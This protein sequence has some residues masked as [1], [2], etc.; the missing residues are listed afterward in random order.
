MQI[1]PSGIKRSPDPNGTESTEPDFRQGGSPEFLKAMI[2][3]MTDLIF[4]KDRQHRWVLLNDAFCN[5]MGCSQTELS[6]K[7]DRDFLPDY[8]ADE[9]VFITG[10]PNEDEEFLIET[11]GKNHIFSIRK[12]LFEDEVGNQFLLGVMRDVTCSK[13]VEAE[14]RQ[15]N[16]RLLASVRECTQALL[17]SEASLLRLTDNVPGIIYQFRLDAD[18]TM[19]FPFVSSGCRDIIKLEPK[20]VQQDSALMFAT[21]HPDDAEALQSA[22][23]YSAQTLQIW[24]SEH[25]A[26][27]TD[28]QLKWIKAISRPT[29]QPDGSILWDGCLIDISDQ[30]AALRERER[31]EAELQKQTNILQLILDSMSDGVIVADE[32]GKVLVFNP[33]A[34]RIFIKAEPDSLTSE[35]SQQYG[36]FL[37]DMETPFPKAQTP[38]LQAIQGK[39][40]DNIEMFIRHP[41]SPDGIWVSTSGRPIRDAHNIFKGGVVVCRDV[42]ERKQAEA[43]LKQQKEQ[44]ETALIELQRTQ[45]QM[46]Q[47][48]KMSSL[49]QLVAGVAHEINNPVNFIHANLSY[50]DQYTQDILE[51]L[52]LYQQH[53][54]DPV[55]EIQDVVEA[56]ELDFLQEDLPK[57]VSSMKVGTQRIS[58][59][60]LSLRN[61]SRL[62]EAERKAVDLHEG[63]D[64]TLMILQHRLK[65]NSHR[66]EIKVIKEYSNLPAVECYAG[67][68]NQVFMNIIANA[69][70][71]L[72]EAV[73][74][75]KK[76]TPAIKIRTQVVEQNYVVIGIADNGVGIPDLAKQRLFDPFF[77]TKPVGKGT[78]M[79]LSISYQIVAEKHGGSLNCVSETGQ[80]TEFA[81]AIPLRQK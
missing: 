62:D 61:F 44:L 32:L 35:L 27:S 79:G 57:L 25:R 1:Q 17:E 42:T 9:L 6:G 78:G 46:L 74:G 33:A 54:P 14:L 34:E 16:E 55:S 29:S 80:D 18:G 43:Q 36:I 2:N 56:I 81:I 30:Q 70:D 22:I 65:K 67:Q 40:V 23:A 51:L 68:L 47:N 12:S 13:Q 45:A 53:Y 72:E 3:K 28:G 31:I 58:D 8:E 26:F 41:Q 64:K 63:I 15:T 66:P 48:E 75:G 11:Q 50:A 20:A 60:V 59:I 52:Q 38:L 39:D 69:I 24:K 5:F 21:V 19:S 77:T 7:S 73:A 76:F 4:V 71:A 37:P 49:G 10:I